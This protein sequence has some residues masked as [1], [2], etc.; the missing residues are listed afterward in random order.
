MIVERALL[1]L[2]MFGG[3]SRSAMSGEVR[4]PLPELVGSYELNDFSLLPFDVMPPR[5]R[6]T[7]IQTGI[8]LEQV[9]QF[10][11]EL[12]GVITFG[13]VTGDG[14]V[15]Q[16]VLAPL[17]GTLSPSLSIGGSAIVLYG[18]V[19]AAEAQAE[20]AIHRLV[21]FPVSEVAPPATEPP[22]DLVITVWLTSGTLTEIPYVVPPPPPLFVPDTNG[23]LIAM[24]L[25]AEVTSAAQIGR[26]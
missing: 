24:P 25:R 13:E 19:E 3:V 5:G 12:T 14:I 18:E 16:S 6:S 22:F 8:F 2:V 4:I 1:C 26:S 15:R 7:Q 17:R 11:I 20:G 21:T 23:V 9:E 10:S